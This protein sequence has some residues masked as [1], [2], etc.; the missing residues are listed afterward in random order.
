MMIDVTAITVLRLRSG[1]DHV[2]FATALPNP[3]FPFDGKLELKCEVARGAG[4]NFVQTRFPGVPCEVRDYAD[5]G[6]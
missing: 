2:Y 4:P 1:P 6:Q 3:I 5:V